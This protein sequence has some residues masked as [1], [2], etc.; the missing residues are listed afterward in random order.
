[1]TNSKTETIF[2]KLLDEDID[3]WR[4]VNAEAVSLDI[5]KILDCNNETIANENWEFKPGDLVRCSPK[6]LDGEK[7]KVATERVKR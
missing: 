4:P 5:Y 3:V 6:I 1:M 2:I 7:V